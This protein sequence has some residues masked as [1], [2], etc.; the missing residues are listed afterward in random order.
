MTIDN[1]YLK[2]LSSDGFSYADSHQRY[3]VQL[4][5][6]LSYPA[7]SGSRD[8]N[9]LF[10]DDAQY[11]AY[12][13]GVHQTIVVANQ[14][15]RYGSFTITSSGVFSVYLQISEHAVDS[16][17]AFVGAPIAISGEGGSTDL[18]FATYYADTPLSPSSYAIPITAEGTHSI[19]FPFPVTSR[20]FLVTHS[21][22]GDYLISQ[23]LPRKVVQRYDIE[24]NSIKAYHVSSTLIDTI[25]L[26]VSDSIVIGPDLIGAKSIDGSKIVDGTISGILMRDGTVTGNKILAGTISGMLITAGAI[27]ADKLSVNQLDAVAANMGNLVVNSGISIGT[28]GYLWAGAGSASAPTTGLKIYTSDGVSRLTTFSGGL[29]QIDVDSA[30]SLTAGANNSVILNASG[31]NFTSPYT[32]APNSDVNRYY[33]DTSALANNSSIIRWKSTAYN[34]NIPGQGVAGYTA[35]FYQPTSSRV[36]MVTQA[37]GNIEGKVSGYAAPYSTDAQNWVTA[38]SQNNSDITLYAEAAFEYT[39]AANL[40]IHA[41]NDATSL[42]YRSSPGGTLPGDTLFAVNDGLL[43]RYADINVNTSISGTL[44][45][46][47]NFKINHNKFTVVPGNGN[48]TIAGNLDLAGNL[49]IGPSS[50]TIRLDASTGNA[51]FD[52]TVTA[53]GFSLTASSLKSPFYGSG[54][55]GEVSFDG[56]VSIGGGNKPLFSTYDAGTST[57]TLTRDVFATALWVPAGMTLKSSGF[58]IFATDNI[59]ID[60]ILHN[61][62]G[63]A[64]GITAGAG[65]LGGYFKA[66][67][68][69]GAGLGTAT[70]GSLG[71]VAV[72]PTASTFVGVLGGRGAAAPSATNTFVGVGPISKA[73]FDVVTPADV[74][75]GKLIINDVAS[76]ST[77]A[78]ST[79]STLWQMS[80]SMGGASGSKS[81]VGTSA[82]SGAGGGGGGFVFLSSPVING[83]GIITAKGGNGGNAAGTNANL[84]GGGG[85][86]GGIVA[87][88]TDHGTDVSTLVD[89]SGGVGGSSAYTVN[90]PLAFADL[91]ATSTTATQATIYPV[92]SLVKNTLYI[93]SIHV[94]GTAGSLPTVDAVNGAGCE[95][96]LYE[97]VLFNSIA[98]PTRRLS[99][100]MGRKDTGVGY[101]VPFSDDPRIVIDFSAAPVSVRYN[102]DQVQNTGVAENSW[103]LMGQITNRTDSATNITTDLGYTPTTNNMQYTVVARSGGTTPV[104]G[105]GNTL[106]NNQTVAPLL[107][108][109]AAFTRQTNT[110]SWT[111]AAAAAAVTL[112]LAMPSVAEP[113]TNGENGK[114]IIFYV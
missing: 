104:A 105:T 88:V 114:V 113:G 95:W 47:S 94:Q 26:Q 51:T 86:G 96:A 74:D 110:M 55:D 79:A 3:K 30:G 76:W 19:V 66:A 73:N 35:G 9:D 15:D 107:V 65:A 32:S 49:H 72:Q 21:G 27:T 17:P 58:R 52:G 77:R 99:I 38:F 31:L 61:N 6:M 100:W 101:N 7:I 57:Y 46:A 14:Q 56:G 44:D 41:E 50:H 37:G 5:L 71:S 112:D 43:G 98:A 16:N 109:E 103:P 18:I 20:A 25:A 83:S 70:A 90:R 28:E 8:P 4:P 1:D 42:S 78:L 84:G 45:V 80:P 63:N 92:T 53:A 54:A 29:K 102:L 60:G 10:R 68:A 93:L 48:T 89:V 87:I 64:S 62:G 85:G 33:L 81:A 75:G 108:S 40:R 97:E 2:N 22:S 59:T 13:S 34:S 82:T 69:G 36:Y 39:S 111:T 91:T 12:P 24:A 106:I 23:L 11:L 67:T